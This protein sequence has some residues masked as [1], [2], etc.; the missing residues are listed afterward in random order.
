M[1][2]DGTYLVVLIA[3]KRVKIFKEREMASVFRE[4]LNINK[5][6]EWQETLPPLAHVER[7]ISTWVGPAGQAGRPNR[8]QLGWLGPLRVTSLSSGPDTRLAEEAGYRNITRAN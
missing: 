8:N 1:E 7:A 4:L 2:L 3:G 5:D 6:E